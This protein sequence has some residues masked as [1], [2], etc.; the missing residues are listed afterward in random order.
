MILAI[1]DFVRD[2]GLVLAEF[3]W[4]TADVAE[5]AARAA[6]RPWCCFVH[7]WDVFTR[8]EAELAAR[9]RGASAVAACSESAAAAAGK[10]IR[11][12]VPVIHH[13][14]DFAEW[15]FQSDRPG[16]LLVCAVGRL[17]PK[18]G[19]DRLLA[20]WPAILRRFP[21]ARLAIAG[22]GSERCLLE[23]QATVLGLAGGQV[24]FLGAL[25]ERG[26]RNLLA[27][28]SMLVL[29]SRRMP[30]GD[31]DGIANVLVEAMAL[32]TVT[33]TTAAGAADEIVEDNVTG[34]LL[35]AEA[36]EADVAEAVIAL[37]ADRRRWGEMVRSARDFVESHFDIQNTAASLSAWLEE[38]VH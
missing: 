28:S 19:F 34:I 35:P 32:G 4:L 2:G 11:R 12:E 25:D 10:A 18:K 13:G 1:A 17:E 22:E 16:G 29:P 36:R 26:V 33:I 7:A 20:A 15:E 9:L 27:E 38:A 3:A 8:P 31:R 14:L 24:E 5:E 21:E 37:A 30:D 6:G 23:T